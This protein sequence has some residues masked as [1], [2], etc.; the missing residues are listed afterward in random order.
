MAT[1]LLSIPKQRALVLLPCALVPLSLIGSS[2]V[3]YMI[4][5]RKD[6]SSN[7]SYNRLMLMTCSFDLICS[8]WWMMGSVPVPKETGF[9]GARGSTRTCELMGFFI[10][11]CFIQ[12]TYNIGV[13]LYFLLTIRFG[14]KQ[15]CFAKQVEPFIHTVAVLFPVIAGISG[16]FLKVFN[17]VGYGNVCYI[18]SY[19]PICQVNPEIECTRGQSAP[20]VVWFF[21]LG[22]G[23]L[24]T[25]FYYAT[26]YLIYNTVRR[27]ELRT[28]RS[29]LNGHTVKARIRAVATQSILYSVFFFNSYFWLCL[30]I[31]F[32]AVSKNPVAI[33]AHKAVYGIQILGQ[34][35]FSLQVR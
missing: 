8:P 28:L 25:I 22:P 23:F 17:P 32:T 9:Y 13:V 14:M 31:L 11:L 7:R 33:L 24:F 10:Q 4:V 26:V 30:L 34:I 16:L 1:S 5:S 21:A 29:S 18:G 15:E 27:Q 3:I 35:F 12:F 19:P 2:C 6:K 20:I